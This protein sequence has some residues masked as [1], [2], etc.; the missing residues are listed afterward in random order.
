MN[1]TEYRPE[2]HYA[3]DRCERCGN[4]WSDHDHAPKPIDWRAE[5]DLVVRQRDALRADL[6]RERTLREEAERAFLACAEAIGVVYEAD[7]HATAPGPVDEVVRYIREARRARDEA[8]PER[9]LV[10]RDGG[11]RMLDHVAIASVLPTCAEHE[12]RIDRML[13]EQDANAPTKRFTLRIA[14]AAVAAVDQVADALACSPDQVVEAARCLVG[15]HEAVKRER[16]AA[17]YDGMS[18]K[19]LY[20]MWKGLLAGIDKARGETSAAIARA[21]R[22]EAE[23]DAEREAHALEKRAH[24]TTWN[25]KKSIVDLVRNLI[26]VI[27][28]D[29]GHKQ[30]EDYL[31]SVSIARASEAV[32]ALMA[33][34][35]AL[36]AKVTALREYATKVTIGVSHHRAVDG[37]V[38]ARH[39][40]AQIEEA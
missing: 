5:F 11:D 22:A 40:L 14:K 8:I 35:D 12:A 21:E 36:R 17:T 38:I 29:G 32:L 2:E 15:A 20:W 3:L 28:R 26:A 34:R 6:A 13:A 4:Y 18:A 25:S 10:A 37:I 39:V 31:L 23:R 7:G 1:C 19:T 16:D 30:S 33:E 24:E 9:A 27:D